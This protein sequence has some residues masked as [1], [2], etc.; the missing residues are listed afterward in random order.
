MEGQPAKC[1]DLYYLLIDITLRQSGR[2]KDSIKYVSSIEHTHKGSI[3]DRRYYLVLANILTL[4]LGRDREKINSTN[5]DFL[6]IRLL[7][8]PLYY[9]QMPLSLDVLFFL[10]YLSQ[11]K[12][13]LNQLMD[14]IQTIIQNE[15]L[16]NPLAVLV[17]PTFSDE[18]RVNAHLRIIRENCYHNVQLCAFQSKNTQTLEEACDVISLSG[19]WKSMKPYFLFYFARTVSFV[20]QDKGDQLISR[21]Y[22]EYGSKNLPVSDPVGLL[23]FRHK[24]RQE[25]LHSASELPSI[26]SGKLKIAVC[27]SGQLR[28]YKGN[29]ESFVEA[30]GL[31]DHDYKVFVHTW[32]NIGMKFPWPAH[33]AR[34]FSQEFAKAYYEC[35]VN[36]SHL[37][38]YI[39][40]QFPNL[41]SLLLDSSISTIDGLREE[42]KTSNIVIE[43]EADERFSSW[44]NQE[45]MHYKIYAAHKLAKNSGE[46]FDLMIRIRPD[47]KLR[48]EKIPDL[49]ELYNNSRKN[50]SV[51]TNRGF[52]T[53]LWSSDFS[54]HDVFA[55]GIPQA[56]DVY[57][58]T[59]SDF[60]F[61]KEENT[62]FRTKQFVGHLTLEHNLYCHGI[63]VD[64]IEQATGSISI[65]LQNPDK[66]TAAE[67]Y[68]AL[69]KDVKNRKITT[70]DQHLL[71]ALVR[72]IGLS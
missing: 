3:T 52:I 44:D 63:H 46:G 9:T 13:A 70:E 37:L 65:N 67:V 39:Q 41:N 47:L 45:K 4:M 16:D 15:H 27:V 49:V 58:N 64:K 55:I 22:K 25:L 51:F 36:R 72:E 34:V 66:F 40:H 8:E 1:R 14:Y 26:G 50:L 38:E 31:G 43:D 35:F 6:A 7:N 24:R 62:Y 42:Y 21:V 28:G 11:Y 57:A 53:R 69:C 5:T 33:A 68:E 20:N 59:Y 19:E 32:R 18:E 30:L 56:M 23:C 29:H 54:M 10:G 61:H 12:D 48:C 71:D 17:S 2:A 60:M